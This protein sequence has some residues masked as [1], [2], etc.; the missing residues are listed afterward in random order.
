MVVLC[1]LKPASLRGIKSTAMVLAAS[2]ADH[3]KVEL[4]T[5]PVCQTAT[6]LIPQPGSKV[7]ERVFFD[8][9]SSNPDLPFMNPK[10]KVWEQVQP[11]KIPSA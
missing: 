11:V 6:L 10:Q 1:N 2:N 4:L 5:P 7:G 3:T 9:Y 8:G